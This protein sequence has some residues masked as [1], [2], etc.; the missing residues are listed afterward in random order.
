[1]EGL[2]M[3]GPRVLP[4]LSLGL[5]AALAAQAQPA[6]LVRDINPAVPQHQSSI[7]REMV[8]LGNAFFMTADDGVYGTEVW[9]SDGTPAGTRI[10]KDICPGSCPSNPS[11]LTVSDGLLFFA[12]DDGA[13]GPQLWVSDGT[14]EGTQ[15]L[16]TGLTSIDSLLDAG[17]RLFFYGVG[18]GYELWTSDGTA[19]G[20]HRVKALAGGPDGLVGR[21]LA[22][23]GGRLLVT[24]Y[25]E[26]GYEPW[27]TDGTEAGTQKVADLRPGS[28][29]S[30]DMTTPDIIDAR[31]DAAPA[32]QGGFLFA[33]DDGTGRALW[34][35]DG[36]PTGTVRLS[37]AVSPHGMAA[38]QGAV[39]FAAGD[40]A[41]GVELWKS[42]GTAAGTVRVKDIL[43]G[44]G[45]SDPRE[46]TAAG[47]HLFFRATDG[48]HGQELWKS[49]GTAAGTSMVADLN[50]GAADAFPADPGAFDPNDFHLSALGG[51]LVFFA[52]DATNGLQLWQTNGTTTVKLSAMPFTNRLLQNL[53]FLEDSVVLGGHFY[54]RPESDTE[55]WSSDG[56]PAGTE[57]TDFAAAT[58]SLPIYAGKTFPHFFGPLGNLLFFGATD[59]I[60][61]F[62][63]WKSDGTAGGTSRV[64]SL[65][66]PPYGSQPGNVH[67]L[68]SRVIF[69]ANSDLWASDGT[70]P[71]TVHLG[72]GSPFG[73][74][75][76]LG[77][78]LFYIDS[79]AQSVE[80]LWKTDGTPQG[81]VS[82]GVLSSFDEGGSMV[83]SG[84]R[85]FVPGFD[86]GGGYSL[87]VT[88]GTPSG[89]L[90]ISG[91]A[92]GRDFDGLGFLA[93]VGGTLLFTVFENGY[94]WELWKSN[95]TAAG[96]TLI[97]TFPVVPP[98]LPDTEGVAPAGGPLLFT[99]RDAAGTELWKSD[100]TAAGTVRVA[101]IAP[102]PADSN[103]HSLT[104]AGGRVYF[105]A[106]D[107]VHG[108]EPWVSDGTAAGTH[109]VADLLPG[110]DSSHPD[111]LTA[112][113]S[114]L[115][116]SAYDGTHGVEA[117]RTGGT[118]LGTRMIQDIAPGP[119]SS[120]P[121]G[122]TAAGTN[123]Y[124]A[125]NDN[126]TGFELWAVPQD[127]VLGTFS[128]VPPSYWAAR[129]IEALATA[130]VTGGCGGGAFCP[131]ALVTR[132]QMSV[133]ILT[134]RATPPPPAT[135]TLFQDVPS[136]YWAGPW[137]EELA[138][139][140]VAAGCSVSPPLFCPNDNL[141]RADMAIWLVNARHETPPPATGTRFADV[142]A[143][144]YAARWIEQ[145][146]AD[147]ITA[148]CGGGNY[149]P[150][151]PIT[152]GEMAVFLA[153]AFHLPLP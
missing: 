78:S 107:G 74:F 124:F 80:R 136:G 37:G 1:M 60:S 145:L 88:D 79:D 23:A 119:L 116:F 58:S 135:G 66:A 90:H 108:A 76:A 146:A 9:K 82:L 128:D 20:T 26:S 51:G 139:E 70:A 141:T 40:A 133:F 122:F 87:W 129:F 7:D 13:R 22:A 69:T 38:F 36:T 100:G 44:T 118:A 151:Q 41:A 21:P 130:G 25:D 47:H 94:G 67:P 15:L 3:R 54:F 91:L 144:Y 8:A 16:E 30:I 46:L 110:P 35:T 92:H 102:G 138:R 113:G 143:T 32:P 115:L 121:T 59:G 73:S 98:L 49:D 29:S 109:L 86:N 4:L 117:W 95:G 18:Q 75:P 112:V 142:P 68:G 34:L 19:A 131:G 12:A 89:T 64:T 114:A 45:G 84:G 11:F 120:S 63:P 24:F 149:C 132:A 10:L 127:A 101:D 81:T 55:I 140:G 99:M 62:E 6:H 123:V 152:R 150:D 71:G 153:V 83:A 48:V 111:N 17:G 28:A 43:P 125:A 61:G 96:T 106:D 2:P 126:T 93:D 72:T 5:L 137:I 53:L 50:P 27:V 85:I 57:L 134:A 56:T 65:G 147:G 77:G 103:P 33:A 52:Y 14:P 148:G 104:V 31:W 97:A 39:Y 105:V 42:D